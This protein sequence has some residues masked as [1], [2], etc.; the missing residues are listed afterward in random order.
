MLPP[1][2]YTLQL[3]NKSFSPN[4]NTCILTYKSEDTITFHNGQFIQCQLPIDNQIIK[5]SYSIMSSFEDF[6]TTKHIDILV[7]RV[8]EGRWSNWLLDIHTLGETIQAV[9]PLW[10]LVTLPHFHTYLLIGTWSG[11]APLLSIYQWLS[12]EINKQIIRWERTSFDLLDKITKL[13][14]NESIILSQEDHADYAHG[15]VQDIL[16]K[17]IDPTTIK[18]WFGVYLCGK[19]AMVDDMKQRL[20]VLWVPSSHIKDEKY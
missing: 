3:T 2:T 4:F 9:W 17:H 5:R 14:G 12:P 19:P 1:S 13:I 7:K 18:E 10:H 15:H 20:I 11:I 8:P 16:W 6:C